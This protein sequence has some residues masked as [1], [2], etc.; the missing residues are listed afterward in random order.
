M[1][2]TFRLTPGNSFFMNMAKKAEILNYLVEKEF[3]SDMSDDPDKQD[4]ILARKMLQYSNLLRKI[5]KIL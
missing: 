2:V 3:G 5:E 4:E 1:K